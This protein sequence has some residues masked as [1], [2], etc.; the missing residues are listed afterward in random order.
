MF[1]HLDRLLQTSP[2]G[3]LASAAINTFT[4][5][6]GKQVDRSRMFPVVGGTGE[7]SP[8]SSPPTVQMCHSRESNRLPAQQHPSGRPTT[9]QDAWGS[10]TPHG[11]TGSLA[12]GTALHVARESWRKQPSALSQPRSVNRIYRSDHFFWLGDLW[13]P[14]NDSTSPVRHYSAA[15]KVFKCVTMEP[16]VIRFRQLPRMPPSS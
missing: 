12:Q 11:T 16:T 14:L 13:S 9:V 3:A 10:G 6:G 7:A 5:R 15:A 4:S 1:E 8:A 2:D